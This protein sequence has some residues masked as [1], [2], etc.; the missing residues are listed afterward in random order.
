MRFKRTIIS[1]VL[2]VT[3]G[4][5]GMAAT[6]AEV[7]GPSVAWRFSTWGKARAFTVG[8]EHLANRRAELEVGGADNARGDAARSV[9]AGCAHCGD[10]VD[11]LGFA[12]HPHGIGASR[13]IHRP[14]FNKHR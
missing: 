1:S 14:A 13:A 9:G 5:A 2:A 8:I 10:A 7:D 4:A 12:N 3:L 11:E 6:A